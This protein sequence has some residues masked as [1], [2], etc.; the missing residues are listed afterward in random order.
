MSFLTDTLGMAGV[1][2]IPLVLA[3]LY[4]LP[5][6][7]AVWR[8]HRNAIPISILTLFFG[9]TILGGVACLAWSFTA[10]TEIAVRR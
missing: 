10:N 1:L 2:C 3:A 7:V 5:A 9:W 8:G 4:F 6:I